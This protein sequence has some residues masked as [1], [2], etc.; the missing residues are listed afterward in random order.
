V[1]GI[2]GGLVGGSVG[3]CDGA[4]DGRSV[5]GGLAVVTSV[6]GLVGAGL[7]GLV[8]VAFA[9]DNPGTFPVETPAGTVALGD[10][11][12]PVALVVFG[13]TIGRAVA[14]LGEWR[15]HVIVEHRH[16]YAAPVSP[17]APPRLSPAPAPGEDTP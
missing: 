6:G 12:L 11:S 8:G 13:T 5:M 9:A 17:A 4:K 2:D 14:A 3:V 1:G 16:T 15:P 10:L 7:G